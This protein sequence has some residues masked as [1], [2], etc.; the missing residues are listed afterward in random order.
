MC[1]ELGTGTLGRV[2][3]DELSGFEHQD[4]LS[5]LITNT[6]QLVLARL[7]KHKTEKKEIRAAKT[8]QP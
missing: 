6:M 8:Q 3:S 7:E 5:V 2:S 4:E 1:K